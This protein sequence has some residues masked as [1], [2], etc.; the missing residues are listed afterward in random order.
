MQRLSKSVHL[1]NKAIDS[2]AKF[3]SYLDTHSELWLL[4]KKQDTSERFKK[5]N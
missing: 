2:I 4:F 5:C 1:N 3:Y